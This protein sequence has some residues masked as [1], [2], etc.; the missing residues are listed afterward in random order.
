MHRSGY[1]LLEMLLVLFILSIFVFSF[2]KNDY[3]NVLK[4]KSMIEYYQVNAYVN[5]EKVSLEFSGSRLSVNDQSLELPLNCQETTFYFNEEGNIS[6]ALTLKCGKYQLVLQLGSG[7]I[8]I[9]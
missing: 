3:L 4:I 6:R 1:T 2:E 9:R 7:V 8:E 5:K